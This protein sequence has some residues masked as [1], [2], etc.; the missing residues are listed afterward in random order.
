[1]RE[2]IRQVLVGIGSALEILPAPDHGPE[3]PAHLMIDR[4]RSGVWPSV[5]EYLASAMSSG[6]YMADQLILF[7]NE[8]NG[9]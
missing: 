9:E 6:G 2:R 1:V 4:Y 5:G 7:D 3:S 8:S